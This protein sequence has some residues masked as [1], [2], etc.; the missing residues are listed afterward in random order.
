MD[1]KSAFEPD[2]SEWLRKF[3]S[4]FKPIARDS[5]RLPSPTELSFWERQPHFHSEMEKVE[6]TIQRMLVSI[7]Q[8]VRGFDPSSLLNPETEFESAT[9]LSDRLLEFVDHSLDVFYGKI[10]PNVPHAL[11]VGLSH[12]GMSLGGEQ[13]IVPSSTQSIERK[14]KH[15]PILRPQLRWTDIDNSNKPF[16]P[17]V[18]E[19]RIRFVPPQPLQKVDDVDKHLA[20]SLGIR[21]D[22]DHGN[23]LECTFG[24][25]AH[26]Y[27]EELGSLTYEKKSMKPREEMM[28]LPLDRTPLTWV[29]TLG[30][31]RQLE[32]CL[33]KEDMFA[34]DLENHSFR[35]FQGYLCLMQISTR[36]QDFLV[37]VIELRSHMQ[38]LLP[39]FT[40][41]HILKVL[42]GCDHDVQWLQRDFGLYLVHVFDTGQAA[43]VLGFPSFSLAYLLDHFCH[44]KVDKKYQLADWR[45]RPLSHEM[46]QYAREDSH[47][48]LYIYDRFTNLLD[49]DQ[50]VDVFVRSRDICLRRYEKT[51]FTETSHMSVYRKFPKFVDKANLLVFR[52]LFQWRDRLARAEDESTGNVLPNKLL[53]RFASEIPGTVKHLLSLCPSFVPPFVRQ[54]SKELVELIKSAVVESCQ[55]VGSMDA[56]DEMAEDEMTKDPSMNLR[57][58]YEHSQSHA[59]TAVTAGEIDE[60]SL[61]LKLKDRMKMSFDA[62]EAS[63]YVPVKE[64]PD[65]DVLGMHG[66]SGTPKETTR[67]LIHE[68][69]KSILVPSFHI[70]TYT[71]SSVSAPSGVSEPLN[72]LSDDM[73]VEEK[74][75]K[76]SEDAEK[77]DEEDG[78]LDD[79]MDD[80]EG[81]DSKED[82]LPPSL[83]DRNPSLRQ[84]ISRRK[85]R[86]RRSRGVVRGIQSTTHTEEEDGEADVDANANAPA[87]KK[88]KPSS[89]F[90][91]EPTDHPSSHQ[92][93][94]KGR[95]GYQK[96][97]GPARF[98]GKSTTYSRK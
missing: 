43:R 72:P 13:S 26:P 60:D 80:K 2:F 68:A 5:S 98:R 42:H 66:F 1:T 15:L 95:G 97:V 63:L 73:D 71:E 76:G 89:I 77:D 37:D 16:R 25:Y 36:N 56:L 23:M 39:S 74:E 29:D 3:L 45:I 17:K 82:V 84:K 93:K 11:K 81:H 64:K 92:K 52:K 48:L 49:P 24:H 20:N 35:S 59:S 28:Y 41:P 9:D 96:R 33:E 34:I 10:D 31:L 90:H 8:L 32:E 79:A 78:T 91:L 94:G 65:M 47:Y 53:Y 57:L 40:N 83:R 87:A 88:P 50:A 61:V 85:T 30:A 55:L 46:T 58:D 18:D 67:A 44:R 86:K 4:S 12:R 21:S 54:R 6:S 19:S 22:R 14:E 7:A 62:N 75:K 38:V 51:L 27:E 69:I 70:E